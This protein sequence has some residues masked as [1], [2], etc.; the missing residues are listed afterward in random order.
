M[1]MPGSPSITP[2]LTSEI[3]SDPG[4]LPNSAEPQELQKIFAKPPSGSQARRSSSP[5]TTRSDPGAT[6]ADAEE[7]PPVRRWQRVQWQ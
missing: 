5:A 1:R 6:R 2:I 4:A 3:S 7:P